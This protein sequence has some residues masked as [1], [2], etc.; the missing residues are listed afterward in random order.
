[1][2]WCCVGSKNK[3]DIPLSDLDNL[4]LMK[5]TNYETI[6]RVCLNMQC[7]RNSFI[8]MRVLDSMRMNYIRCRK[9]A[10]RA[11]SKRE[12][13]RREVLALSLMRSRGLSPGPLRSL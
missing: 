13:I 8:L 4:G 1:M 12:R 11:I 2:I 6:L 5:N 9:S 3:E 7:I 10:I